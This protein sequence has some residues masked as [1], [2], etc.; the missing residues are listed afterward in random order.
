MS[1]GTL[2]E[3]AA[4]L[5]LA[6]PG[7]VIVVGKDFDWSD[8]NGR[9]TVTTK[10]VSSLPATDTAGGVYNS[11]TRPGRSDSVVRSTVTIPGTAVW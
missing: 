7:N 5:E 10:A 2:Q 9:I 1:L 11:W 3:L 8:L 6:N 4:G